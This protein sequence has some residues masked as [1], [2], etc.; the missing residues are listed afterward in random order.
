MSGGELDG[1]KFCDI[2]A[3]SMSG[4]EGFAILHIIY[5]DLQMVRA[6]I[7]NEP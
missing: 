4:V 7:D 1:A 5:E 6:A 2:K 3:D